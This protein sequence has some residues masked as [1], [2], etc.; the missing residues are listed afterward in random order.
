MSTNNNTPTIH[1]QQ[2]RDRHMD[3]F[4]AVSEAVRDV[5]ISSDEFLGIAAD[6]RTGTPELTTI[7]G[8]TVDREKAYKV[9]KVAASIGIT[10]DEYVSDVLA[11]A[12]IRPARTN[13]IEYADD[14][15]SLTIRVSGDAY[16]NV[17]AMRD[18]YV[19]WE[20][21]SAYLS[22][23]AF[24]GWKFLDA[25]PQLGWLFKRSPSVGL[26]MTAPDGTGYEVRRTIP[27]V[28]GYVCQTFDPRST[29]LE[30]AFN[31]AGFSTAV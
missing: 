17:A 31:A 18:A 16:A 12:G 11:R 30:R 2:L 28:A 25:V 6:A 21:G 19:S 7:G 3:A 24:I 13:G 10:P 27:T 14:G 22:P 29:G 23:A 15:D 5:E 20:P 8:V 9:R 1:P 4:T 26:D